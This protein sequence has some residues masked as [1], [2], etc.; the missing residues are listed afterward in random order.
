MVL[1]KQGQY[2]SINSLSGKRVLTVIRN[3]FLRQQN[4]YQLY[5]GTMSL[6][7][8]LLFVAATTLLPSACHCL[9]SSSLSQRIVSTNV[10]WSRRTTIVSAGGETPTNLSFTTTK[11]RRLHNVSATSFGIGPRLRT[12]TNSVTLGLH[13]EGTIAGEFN[14]Q[15]SPHRNGI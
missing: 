1:P 3:N 2:G 7:V 8:L 13:H 14:S 5:W 9:S 6:R 12:W 15:V 10:I 11:P 4:G